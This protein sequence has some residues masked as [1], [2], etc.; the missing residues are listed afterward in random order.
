MKRFPL[1]PDVHYDYAD[2]WGPGPTDHHGT[3]IFAASRSPVVAVIDGAA[4]P[5]VDPKGGIVVY[6]SNPSGTEVYYYA[7]LDDVDDSLKGAD[8]TLVKAGDPIGYVGNTGNAAHGPPHVHFQARIGGNLVDPYGLLRDA[9]PHSVP[10]GGTFPRTPRP[11]SPRDSIPDRGPF[12]HG[13][14][15]VAPPVEHSA[16]GWGLALLIGLWMAW[17]TMKPRRAD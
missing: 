4:H 8:Y 7:H 1:P 12:P 5:D 13:G 17:E 6:L 10:G 15:P 3:D 16:W 11:T 14:G 9:D 2:R